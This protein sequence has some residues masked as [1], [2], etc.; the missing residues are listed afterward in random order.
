M[1]L[2]E[3]LSNWLLNEQ[4][5]AIRFLQETVQEAS[6]TG[7]ESG[8]QNLIAKKLN[9]MGLEVDMWHPDGE[10][11]AK[12]PYFC[13]S[14]TNFNTSPNVVG[15]WRGKGNGRSLVLN[16]HIDV[17]PEGDL[18]QWDDH[19]YSGKIIDGKLYGR[20]STDMKGG[21][22]SLLLA[23]QALKETGTILEGDL[24]FHSVIE[25][26]SGGAGTLAAVLRGYTADAAIIPE[27]TNMKIFP[28]QQ[29]SMWFKVTIKGK[30]AHGGTRY[31]GISAIEK[32]AV[33][34]EAIQSLETKRNERITDPL[35]KDIPIPV[36][37]NIGKITGGN[38]PSS[39]PDTVK[40]EGRI[41]VAPN[42]T[43]EEVKQELEDYLS[44]IQDDWL[45][46]NPV[47]VEWFGAQWLPGSIETDHPLM[48]TLIKNYEHVKKVRPT[49][50]A[51]PWGTD[52][53]LLSQVGNTPS[54]VFGP[55]VTAV[56]HYPNEYIEISK[57]IE[58]A[59]IIALTIYDWCGGSN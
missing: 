1:L 32:T 2:K 47:T 27:P 56:A 58:A 57:I 8:V 49:I 14:R 51:S 9:D 33:V 7:N 35:Y 19:P 24:Y 29:G 28:A 30:S 17:V 50:E 18:K 10:E 38:W 36:P 59:E 43:L 15:I 12:H 54:I 3:K 16:G 20:G 55:G 4:D 44:S 39:V 31:E 45:S 5:K 41:G 48:S 6:T 22:L 37:I 42:E 21:N 52:G 26:E 46:E 53:G 13:A 40:L 25:E 23:I 34:L 11:L